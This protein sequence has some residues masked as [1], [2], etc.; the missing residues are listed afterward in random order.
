MKWSMLASSEGCE[1]VGEMR[2]F[3]LSFLALTQH[4]HLHRQQASP[5]DRAGMG[6]TSE[7]VAEVGGENELTSQDKERW[8]SPISPSSTQATLVGVEGHEARSAHQ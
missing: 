5:Q 8:K 1:C 7:L 3:H 2:P 4:T 6:E